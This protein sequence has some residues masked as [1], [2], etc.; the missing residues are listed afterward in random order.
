MIRWFDKNQRMI[1]NGLKTS[2]DGPFK[3]Y[4]LA[5]LPDTNKSVSETEFLVIDF[6]TTGL[7]SQKDHVISVGYT[8]IKNNKIILGASDHHVVNTDKRL[9]SENVSIH[10]LTDD[11]IS[12]GQS[13]TRIIQHLLKLISGKVLVAHYQKIEYGFLQQVCQSLYSSGLPMIMLDTL[14][15]EKTKLEK[16]NQPIV[17]NQLRLFNLRDKYNLPRY[18]AHNAM[19]DAIATAELFLA[20]LKNINANLDKI[21]I[22]ELI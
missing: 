17:A 1:N 2:K 4:L 19:E 21:R 10:Q 9:T 20:Q 5:G 14:L 22:K 18:K 16:N 7:N 3:D 15:I 8:L 6:E 13:I 12:Q 11:V